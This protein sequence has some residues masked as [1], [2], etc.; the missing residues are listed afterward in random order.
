MLFVLVSNGL[1]STNLTKLE[2]FFD[3]IPGC[4]RLTVR[5][6][7]ELLRVR[8]RHGE[9]GVTG[10]VLTGS[11]RN[12]RTPCHDCSGLRRILMTFMLFAGVPKLC[13]CYAHQV[14]AWLHGA[15]LRQ[16]PARRAGHVPIVLAGH[17]LFDGLGSPAPMKLWHQTCVHDVPPGFKVVARDLTE[18]GCRIQGLV[19]DERR[20]YMVQFHPEALGATRVVLANFVRLAAAQIRS[21]RAASRAPS[22]RP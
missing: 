2:R 21:P 18:G 5:T 10:F 22:G 15:G 8:E 11:N 6:E 4:R 1:H 19:D 12:S 3:A 20:I 13:I 7:D 17:P 9:G 14:V 16:L